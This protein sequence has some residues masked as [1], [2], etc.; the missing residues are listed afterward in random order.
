[1]ARA[2]GGLVP[3]STERTSFTK[4]VQGGRQMDESTSIN[5]SM[6][7]ED[8]AGACWERGVAT[9]WAEDLADSRQDLYTSDDGEPVERGPSP[10]SGPRPSNSESQRTNRTRSDR[11]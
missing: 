4:D 8:D 3:K 2:E 10:E 7:D 6:D 11:R 9:E 1:M 5:L